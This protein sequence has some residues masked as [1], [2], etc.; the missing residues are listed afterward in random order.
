MAAHSEFNLW[1]WIKTKPK[2]C[3]IKDI[4][5]TKLEPII[6]GYLVT[7]DI[8]LPISEEETLHLAF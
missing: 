2:I 8:W 4:K 5:L 6:E 7:R 3:S 1:D